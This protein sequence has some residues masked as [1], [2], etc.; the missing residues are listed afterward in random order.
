MVSGQFFRAMQVPP[1][2]G[3]YLS[4]Q[5]DQPGGGSTGFGVVISEGFWRRWFNGAPD[6]IGRN[7][8]IANAPFT[9]VG[10]MPKRFIGARS[11]LETLQ[12]YALRYLGGAGH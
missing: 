8:T 2:L 5:D 12:I 4:P 9:I 11:D 3:R 10:V 6:V 7:I 1:L